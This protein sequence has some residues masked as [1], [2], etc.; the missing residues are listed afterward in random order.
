MSI[1]TVPTEMLLKIFS[2]MLP[3]KPFPLASKHT[4]PLILCFICRGWRFIA[5]N[6]SELW[7]TIDVPCNST[8]AN[9]LEK[10]NQQIKF[11]LR[12]SSERLLSIGIGF[13]KDRVGLRPG[14]QQILDALRILCHVLD[15]W[16]SIFIS[17]GD[18]AT[19]VEDGRRVWTRRK[20][21]PFPQLVSI[22]FLGEIRDV[23]EVWGWMAPL[24]PVTAPK[25][26]EYKAMGCSDSA[27]PHRTFVTPPF[28]QLTS[29]TMDHFDSINHLFDILRAS[30]QLR[31]LA[32]NLR[33]ICYPAIN[34]LDL[35]DEFL[36]FENLESLDIVSEAGLCNFWNLL[37]TPRLR[38][39]TVTFNGCR[40]NNTDDTRELPLWDHASFLM[41][42]HASRCPLGT[43]KLKWIELNDLI[44][45]TT[46]MACGRYLKHFMVEG[47]QG[48]WP[49]GCPRVGDFTIQ[50]LLT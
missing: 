14:A 3:E 30:A 44:L 45:F 22:E 6:V 31:H 39:L 33:W 7:T 48:S 28:G 1:T 29:L 34:T 50:L 43:L 36:L 38:S 4:A 20:V 19:I 10:Y 37:R 47:N 32:I 8:E 40:F 41:F 46:L 23:N 15:R 27:P 24:S 21:V 42:L 2:Y 35:F 26:H 18:A 5:L 17:V 25:L 9:Q 12:H 49:H 11:W 13:N 16:H